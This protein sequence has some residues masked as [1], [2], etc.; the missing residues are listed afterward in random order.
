MVR[1]FFRTT[2]QSMVEKCFRFGSARILN[3]FNEELLRQGVRLF[4]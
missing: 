3:S 2:D 1:I 4:F